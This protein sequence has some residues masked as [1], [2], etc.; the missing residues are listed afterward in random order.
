MNKIKAAL[1]LIGGLIGSL[2]QVACTASGTSSRSLAA[3]VYFPTTLTGNNVV[4]MSVGACGVNGYENEPCISITLCTPGTTTCQTIDNILVDTGSYGLKVFKSLITI[5][6][7]QISV[8]GGG[9][10]ASCTGY[11]DGSGH[12]G[13]VV[14]ADVKLGGL[15]T[16]ATVTAG[17]PIVTL[18]ASYANAS[19]C[20]D[21]PDTT[22]A[23]AGFNG[24]IGVGPFVEDCSVNDTGTNPCIVA[25]KSLYWKCTGNNCQKTAVPASDQVANPVAKLAAP[26]NTGVVLKL[27][28]VSSTGAGAAYGYMVLGIGSD[29]NN[30]ATGTTIFPVEN[31][32]TFVTTYNGTSNPSGGSDYDYAF[33]DSGTN[34]NGFPRLGGSP[35]LC[36]GGSG[37]YCPASEINVYAIMK[38]GSVTQQVTFKVGN[39]FTLAS[40]DP[41]SKVFNNIAFDT[42]SMGSTVADIPFDWGLPF[43]LGRSVYVGIKGTS[44]TINGSATAGPFWAF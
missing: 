24:I 26:Y 9:S 13:E 18:N 6:L 10:L 28:S 21:D 35:T 37:F 15:S 12:W 17:I 25:A 7:S 41:Q 44:P 1:I 36:S 23:V 33:I 30:T 39:M 11:L 29:S 20:S 38:S 19:G 40:A 3:A 14:R 34:F 5:P 27:P 4:P 8:T 42:S 22:P 31:D 43:F 2:N 32:A 16:Q